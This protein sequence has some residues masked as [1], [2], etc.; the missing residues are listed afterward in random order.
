MIEVAQVK[1]IVP[2]VAGTVEGIRKG[3]APKEYKS[4]IIFLGIGLR[5]L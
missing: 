1:S 3:Q 2:D 4:V 5:N